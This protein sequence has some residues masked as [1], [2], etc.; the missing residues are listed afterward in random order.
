MPMHPRIIPERLDRRLARPLTRQAG[1]LG[2]GLM[3]VLLL[4]SCG[5]RNCLADPDFEQ[6]GRIDGLPKTTGQWGGDW[7]EVVGPQ[8]GISPHTGSSMLHF[9]HTA[10]GGKEEGTASDTMQLVDVSKYTREVA[11]GTSTARLSAWFNRVAG[12]AKTDTAFQ[13]V[14]RAYDGS[15]ADFPLRCQRPALGSALATI[16]SDGDVRTWERADVSLKI[17]PG[18]TYLGAWVCAYENV[19][20]DS[21]LQQ[22]FAGHYA[23]SAELVIES[24]PGPVLGLSLAAGL[25]VAAT[26]GRRWW[27]R[28]GA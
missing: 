15:P 9:M 11:A 26:L 8:D 22:E 7:N 19:V 4:G 2:L 5:P 6:R 16:Y 1:L 20:D 24:S 13:V 28:R 27:R 3:V 21:Y 18:T 25:L 17:P 14:L 12:D 10:A 23:D